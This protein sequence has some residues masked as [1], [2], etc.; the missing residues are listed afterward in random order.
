ML[1]SSKCDCLWNVW[2]FFLF[3]IVYKKKLPPKWSRQEIH[4]NSEKG[5]KISRLF[6][7]QSVCLSLC[8]DCLSVCIVTFLPEFYCCSNVFC[9]SV[10][11]LICWHQLV[12]V[13]IPCCSFCLIKMVRLHG[14]RLEATD[15]GSQKSAQVEESSEEDENETEEE[16]GRTD[17]G[18]EK[19]R[20]KRWRTW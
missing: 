3:F 20:K 18:L 8:I 1:L 12:V 17:N 7:C 15:D 4:W 14:F 19:E 11:S 5:W 6:V 13:F 2:D 16:R 9:Y 10:Y